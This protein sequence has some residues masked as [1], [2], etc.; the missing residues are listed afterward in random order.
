MKEEEA[1]I[2]KRK[3]SVVRLSVV[4]VCVVINKRRITIIALIVL[5]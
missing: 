5:L 1:D 4:C 3:L 2:Q